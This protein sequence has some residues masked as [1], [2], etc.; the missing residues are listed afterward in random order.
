MYYERGIMRNRLRTAAVKIAVNRNESPATKAK[1]FRKLFIQERRDWS[2]SG[3]PRIGWK[4]GEVFEVAQV[5]LMGGDW[6]S[7]W[8]D[9]GYYIAQSF[10]WLWWLYAIITPQHIIE[11]AC[12]KFE[13]RAKGE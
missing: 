5:F 12:D 13:R 7:E 6:V 10:D 9:C 2:K 3:A 11:C 4:R 8:G 1:A